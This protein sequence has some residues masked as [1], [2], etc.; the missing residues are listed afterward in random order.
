MQRDDE[1]QL[2]EGGGSLG[3]HTVEARE[4]GVLDALQVSVGH[5]MAI[6]QYALDPVERGRLAG[7]APGLGLVE[8]G[9]MVLTQVRRQDGLDGGSQ[10][11]VDLN[12]ELLVGR[13]VGGA[14]AG[15]LGHGR[16]HDVAGE[17]VVASPSAQADVLALVHRRHRPRESRCQCIIGGEGSCTDL[18]RV[19][20]EAGAPHPH[21]DVGLACV[22]PRRSLEWCEITYPCDARIQAFPCLHHEVVLS[23]ADLWPVSLNQV[24]SRGGGKTYLVWED[25]QVSQRASGLTRLGIGLPHELPVGVTFLRNGPTHV[26]ESVPFL[27]RHEHVHHFVE[28]VAGPLLA[29]VEVRDVRGVVRIG[30]PREGYHVLARV[31]GPQRE[32]KRV[33]VSVRL[34]WKFIFGKGRGEC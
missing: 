32:G 21:H 34:A 6:V 7:G 23:G 33:S 26:P 24:M 29:R 4:D 27:R 22:S 31:L 15:G 16:E 14:A 13:M 3:R 11:L 28:V 19:A 25:G 9:G 17:G 30:A 8:A 2:R 18:Q 1:V 20:R 10:Q 12:A 5:M